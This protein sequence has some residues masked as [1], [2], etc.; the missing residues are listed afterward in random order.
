M[1]P[2]VERARAI[3]RETQINCG[4]RIPEPFDEVAE[5]A[6]IDAF[7]S[8]EAAAYERAARVAKEIDLFEGDSLNNSD[9]RVTIAAGILALSPA[10][11]DGA[12]VSEE[13]PTEAM[14]EAGADAWQAAVTGHDY[15]QIVT[16]I[17]RAMAAARLAGQQGEK[18]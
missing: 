3:L 10:S 4:C 16:A 5:F 14:I 12:G 17:Y 2:E 7:R 18:P 13:E 15:R 8:A 9:P 11:G 6:I 1:Q